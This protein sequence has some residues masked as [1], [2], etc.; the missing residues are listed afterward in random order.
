MSTEEFSFQSELQELGALI[1]QLSQQKIAIEQANLKSKTIIGNI[2]RELSA[3]DGDD[4]E[5]GPNLGLAE[6]LTK[7]SGDVARAGYSML[8][9][10]NGAAAIA[11]LTLIGN[12]AR[13]DDSSWKVAVENLQGSMLGF[14]F[15]LALS[16]LGVFLAFLALR[17]QT[18]KALKS[19]T[20]DDGEHCLW[21]ASICGFFSL[22]F[23]FV[24]LGLGF[25]G[26]KQV[27]TKDEPTTLEQSVKRID[28]KTKGIAEKVGTIEGRLNSLAN[29]L[30]SDEKTIHS[31][32]PSNEQEPK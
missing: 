7:S 10:I 27:T 18:L 2:R 28:E 4:G 8:V 20:P 14:G 23:F 9:L 16:V 15:G 11:V 31:P 25:S 32:P 29:E 1:D 3:A 13:R 22:I 5:R 21:V 30:G 12:L 26:I 24:G 17:G 6:A 19:E